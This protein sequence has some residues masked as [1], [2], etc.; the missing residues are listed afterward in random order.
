MGYLLS[1][2]MRY[3]MVTMELRNFS[4]AAE[5]LCITRSPLSKVICEMEDYLGGML[6]KRK[7]NEL[8]PTELALEYYAKFR[9]VYNELLELE[10]DIQNNS[11][12]KDLLVKFDITFPELLYKNIKIALESS[13]AKVQC[14]RKIIEAGDINELIY[15]KNSVIF[16]MRDISL[17]YNVNHEEWFSD[18]LVLISP[19]DADLNKPL[20]LF[21]WK[22]MNTHYY[23]QIFG[24]LLGDI[25]KTVE[26]VEHNWDILSVFYNVHLGKGSAIITPKLSRFLSIDGVQSTVLKNKRLKL[27]GYHCLKSDYTA[28]KNKVKKIINSFV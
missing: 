3:F 19:K 23:K 28:E 18:E 5:A 26:F 7:Y 17:S 14:E 13:N 10:D 2:K 15:N 9:S 24:N 11:K 12:I 1:K 4:K 25:N 21:I 20:K 16:S 6:F 27:R 8:E 22:D